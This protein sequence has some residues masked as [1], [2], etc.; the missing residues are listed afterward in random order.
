MEWENEHMTSLSSEI[1][2]SRRKSSLTT[3][4][5]QNPGEHLLEWEMLGCDLLG[6]GITPFFFTIISTGS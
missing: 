2:I 3:K 6:T 5:E 4:G 1:L